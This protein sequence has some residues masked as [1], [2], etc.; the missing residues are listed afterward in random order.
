MACCMAELHIWSLKS[1]VTIRDIDVGCHTYHDKGETVVT[2]YLD[3]KQQY[4]ESRDLLWTPKNR[5]PDKLRDL[6]KEVEDLLANHQ[7]VF[8]RWRSRRQFQ[9]MLSNCILLSFQVSVHSGDVERIL[10]DK[11]LQGKFCSE[12]INCA[13]VTDAFV[14]CTFPEKPKLGYAFFSKRPSSG[15][16][17]SKKIDKM[18]S[19]DPK[20]THVDLPGLKTK[21]ERKLS[22]NA[23][24]EWVLVWCCAGR[25][26]S[27]AWPWTPMTSDKERAN[28]ILYGVN[29]SKLEELCFVSTEY[30]PLDVSFSL[31]Q[32]R[33]IYTLEGVSSASSGDH[34][35][36]T[37]IYECSKTRIQRAT[38][39]TI[40]LKAKVVAHGRNHSE[41]KLILGCSD[42]KLVLYDESKRVTQFVQSDLV[43]SLITWHPGSCLVFVSGIKGEIQ[44]FDM[45]L[46]P[47]NILTVGET[48]RSW[49]TLQLSKCFRSPITIGTLLWSYSTC[50]SDCIADAQDSLLMIFNGGPISILQLHLGVL[51]RGQLGPQEL[52]QQYLNHKQINEA[53]NLLNVMNWN[54]D[55]GSCFTC[56]TTIINNLLKLPLTPDREAAL[57]ASL[58][59]FYAPLR[60]LSDV[61][62]MDYRDPISRLARRFFHHLLRYQRFEKAF[63]LAVDLHSRDLFMDIHYLALDKGEMALA[64][65]AKQKADEIEQEMP[66]ESDNLDSLSDSVEEED[67]SSESYSSGSEEGEPQAASLSRAPGASGRDDKQST[68]GSSRSSPKPAR[69]GRHIEREAWYKAEEQIDAAYGLGSDLEELHLEPSEGLANIP[70]DVYTQVLTDNPFGWDS[71]KQDGGQRS[72]EAQG[73]R[74]ERDEEGER[75][76][77]RGDGTTKT[78][79]VIH[80]GMV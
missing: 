20:I 54:T 21:R 15:Q 67:F 72:R 19:Y 61:I 49:P 31:S 9:V 26:D 34:N 23:S 42:S 41:D 80:F 27:S 50:L 48:S 53:V 11:A 6:L 74:S 75:Q 12:T 4:A 71:Q 25:D 76:D 51:S 73:A 79:K 7:V 3:E 17:T 2:G 60:P 32:P 44:C 24:Q 38:V 43:P 78:V 29:G 64:T 40:P 13:V 14:V 1:S 45:A 56:L 70:G 39:T 8:T 16:D 47:L 58:G 59:S 22:V 65:V 62:V 69:A 30:D 77:R 57:E 18:S 28:V 33:H 35:V 36:D 46:N 55:S 10:I 5:R 68:Q 52:I 66:S 37:C 63:L